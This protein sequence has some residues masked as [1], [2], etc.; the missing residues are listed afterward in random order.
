MR[1]MWRTEREKFLSAL[2]G[3]ERHPERNRA[4]M[5]IMYDTGCRVSELAALNLEDYDEQRKTLM[6]QNSKAKG[7]P[8]REVP[9]HYRTSRA[10]K[11]WLRVRPDSEATA[12]FLS[13][14]GNR[15]S[16]RRISEE[17]EIVCNRAGVTP[18]GVHTL[19]HTAATRLLDDKVLPVHQLS[20]RLGHRSIQTTYKYYVH[21]SVEEEANAIQGSRL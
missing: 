7:K 10:I 4:I 18:T 19:R 5:L 8:K 6:I 17:Y 11:A 1:V 12:M 13:Q 21:G 9:I 14:K 2:N 15:L 20:R 3:L 16:I